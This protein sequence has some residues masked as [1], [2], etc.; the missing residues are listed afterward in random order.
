[1]YPC[2]NLGN[3][4][5]SLAWED[6]LLFAKESGFKGIDVPIQPQVPA[7]RYKEAL[8][9]SDLLPGGMALPFHV[10][11]P[12]AKMADALK[13][14]PAICKTA[15][16][17]GQTRFYT[18]IHSFSDQMPW[19][20]NYRF[21]VE[22]LSQAAQ[23]LDNYGC[24]LGLEFLG[25]KTLREGHRFSFVHTLEEMLDL[26]AAIGPNL[27]LLLDAYH[28][29]TS[30]GTV[31][32]LHNLENRQVVYVHVNDAPAGVPV[33]RQQDL[34]RRLPG[35]S[36]VIDLTGFMGALQA[37]GYD[38]PVVPEPFDQ[39]LSMLE[40]ASA[41]RKVGNAMQSIWPVENIH[42]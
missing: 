39:S 9:Q 7:A 32:E 20:E 27:G 21:H 1:M 10:S 16:E 4:G 13:V 42:R 40:P 18:W 2:L 24:R 31:E 36:G 38:G 17:I 14:L 25:P 29:Y 26:C 22:R 19:K 41:I 23:I 6:C 33:D 34:V 11:D 12:D 15:Q 3:I 35:E 8:E 5:I 30:L 37:I 28:W